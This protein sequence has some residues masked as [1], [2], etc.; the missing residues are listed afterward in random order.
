MPAISAC[1]HV[2]SDLGKDFLPR[3]L[4]RSRGVSRGVVL[5]RSRGVVL[6]RSLSVGRSLSVVLYRSLSV[7]LY[8][9]LS[10][11]RGVVLYRRGSRV[12]GFVRVGFGRELAVLP[13]EVSK[14]MRQFREFF[15]VVDGEL[16]DSEHMVR[17]ML[18][19]VESFVGHLGSVSRLLCGSGKEL[20]SVDGENCLDFP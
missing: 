16:E 20:L 13:V 11:G 2:G 5:Y 12:D 8:R 4:Y 19:M 17:V 14:E 6:Y 3:L 9:S 18:M 10:V 7:V 15:V 1:V